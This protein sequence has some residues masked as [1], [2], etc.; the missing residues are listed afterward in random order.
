MFA[1]ICKIFA[2]IGKVFAKLPTHSGVIGLLAKWDVDADSVSMGAVIVSI[3]FSVDYTAHV[4]SHFSRTGC[5][6]FQTILNVIG[7]FQTILRHKMVKS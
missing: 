5:M 6:N 2:K 3:G 7:T 1:K 4:C